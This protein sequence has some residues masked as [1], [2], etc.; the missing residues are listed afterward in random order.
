M[1]KEIESLIKETYRLAGSTALQVQN[2]QNNLSHLESLV[3]DMHCDVLE[4]PAEKKVVLMKTAPFG[5]NPSEVLKEYDRERN[6]DLTLQEIRDTL[7]KMREDL[8]KPRFAGAYISWQKE[9]I[10]GAALKCNDPSCQICY[11]TPL[12]PKPPRLS[13]QFAQ[14]MQ[15]SMER[16]GYIYRYARYPE[17]RKLW[18][19]TDLYLKTHTNLYDN[20]AFLKLLAELPPRC[21]M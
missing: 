3:K 19:G 18:M 11:P 10:V 9:P 4:R 20:E 17:Y 1:N 13:E 15:E 8:L 6:R 7:Q 21:I 12:P 2:L 5:A 14:F 16:R